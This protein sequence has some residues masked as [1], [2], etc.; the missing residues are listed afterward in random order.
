MTIAY[1]NLGVEQEFL[2][3]F[4]QALES[5]RMAMEF[6]DKYLGNKDGVTLNMG[7]IY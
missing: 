1:H 2:K 5:Y 6:S 7:Q 3:Q 4:N